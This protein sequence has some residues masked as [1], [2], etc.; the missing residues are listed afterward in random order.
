MKTIRLIPSIV[1]SA[2]SLATSLHA[3]EFREIPV[4]P[5]PAEEPL[6]MEK[7]FKEEQAKQH[8]DRLPP[9]PDEHPN[10]GTESDKVQLE[11]LDRIHKNMLLE[12]AVPELQKIKEPDWM[13]G[14]GL[15]PLD[16]F[17]REH[18]RIEKD[19]GARV[20]FV[21]KGQPASTA[22]IEVNDIII[23]ANGK[24][25]SKVEDLREIVDHSGKEGRPV[26]LIVV[27]RGE[28]RPV[29]VIPKSTRPP[30]SPVEVRP[31]GSGPE[32]RFAELANR[33]E[34]QEKQIRELQKEVRRLRKELRDDQDQDEDKE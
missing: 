12:Q 17:L 25:V 22:G 5:D 8:E 19:S 23:S 20:S 7:L 11:M 9:I 3:Q 27:H 4:K 28:R 10:P 34:R 32:R 2:A 33:L 18:L 16:P 24:N 31:E 21:A 1:F 14:L 13:I 6:T 30:E 29:V 26:A 15:E